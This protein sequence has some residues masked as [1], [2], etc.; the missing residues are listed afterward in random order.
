MSLESAIVLAI[1]VLLVIY[2]TITMLR[3]EKF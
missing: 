2:L 3:P 1:A